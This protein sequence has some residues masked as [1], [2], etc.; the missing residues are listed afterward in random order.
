MFGIRNRIKGIFRNESNRCILGSCFNSNSF[1]RDCYPQGLHNLLLYQNDPPQQNVIKEIPLS[2]S[3]NCVTTS[4]MRPQS[5]RLFS[6]VPPIH[7]KP[8]NDKKY[9][10]DEESLKQMEM[11]YQEL[12]QLSNE[13]LHHDSL[14][15]TTGFVPEISDDEYDALTKR[16][17]EICQLYPNLKEKLERESGLG[18]KA[19][20]YGGRVGTLIQGDRMSSKTT[21]TPPNTDDRGRKVVHLENAP[22]QSL[23]NAMNTDDVVKWL[24]RVKKILQ[25]DGRESIEKSIDIIAEPKLDGLSLSLRYGLTKVSDSIQY[26]TLQSGA[27]R[28]DGRRGEDITNAIKTIT[29]A[30][31]DSCNEN[32]NSSGMIPI[33]FTLNNKDDSKPK[34]SPPET[35]EV[36]GEII[37]PKTTFN[38]LMGGLAYQK[39]SQKQD[40]DKRSGSL[41]PSQFSNARN[42]ASGILLRRKSEAELT[43]DEVKNTNELRSS[44]RFYAYSIAFS[45]GPSQSKVNTF[46]SNGQELR[47]MLSKIGFTIPNPSVV[48]SIPLK[49]EGDIEKSDC[50]QLMNYHENVMTKRDNLSSQ[51]NSDALLFDFDID[52]AVYK[53]SSIQDRITLGEF[54]LIQ[55][56]TSYHIIFFP[57]LII[58][59]D[60]LNFKRFFISIPSLG[61]RAQISSQMCCV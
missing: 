61:N 5:T 8:D 36:R 41:L 27:T 56:S 49:S 26:Y 33:E 1:T 20:R 43:V 3:L 12:K 14:Y 52:G 23:D 21:D 24:N 6:S 39:G 47:D 55:S 7:G 44:L 54:I 28:G 19:T 58:E 46:Y 60:L 59:L 10:H 11:T 34:L 25:S 22:M 4:P 9:P 48:T 38:K 32:V 50:V 29:K 53:V 45:A 18:S 37:L 17:A 31:N 16:E 35:I 2:L 13:I 30:K 40:G 57:F 51:E 15:Y 42:A